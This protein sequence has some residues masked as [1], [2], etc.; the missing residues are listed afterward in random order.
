MDLFHIHHRPSEHASDMTLLLNFVIRD[1]HFFV[2]LLT[3]MVKDRL[4]IDQS[5]CSRIRYDY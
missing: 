5:T 1:L 3:E 2:V 4:P